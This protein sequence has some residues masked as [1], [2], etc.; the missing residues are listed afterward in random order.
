MLLKKGSS[1]LDVYQLKDVKTTLEYTLNAS[2]VSEL[3]I[4]K[5]K[6]ANVLRAVVS[7]KKVSVDNLDDL[8]LHEVLINTGIVKKLILEDKLVH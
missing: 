4:R 2:E 3:P 7:H 6:M 8:S 5:L 1:L